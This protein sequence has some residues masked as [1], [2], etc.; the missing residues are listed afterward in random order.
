MPKPSHPLKDIKKLI[1]E[2]NVLINQNALSDAWDVFGW[3]PDKIKKCLLKLNDKYHS[4][5]REKNHFHKSEP[6]RRFPNTMIDSY[7]AK[8]IME[9][10]SV[11]T[12]IYIDPKSEM[13]IISSFKEL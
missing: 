11:Y 10:A 8:K 12:H 4:L 7:K 6:H 1:R 9:D 3:R 2:N 5:N 13:L